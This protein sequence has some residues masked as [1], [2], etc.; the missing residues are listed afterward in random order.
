MSSVEMALY[1]LAAINSVMSLALAFS[2]GCTRKQKLGQVCVV[3]LLPGLGAVLMGAF[4]YSEHARPKFGSYHPEAP[5]DP[6]IIMH[7]H[8]RR[9]PH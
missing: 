1:V 9:P 7:Y 4:L 2:P 5:E 8:D 6:G 3:W